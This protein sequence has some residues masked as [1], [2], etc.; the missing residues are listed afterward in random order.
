[1]IT[2]LD[3]LLIAA[4]FLA[5]AFGFSI[6]ARLWRMGR[7]E[8]RK[9]SF[10]SLA[11]TLF[12]HHRILERRG[13]GLAH[14][15]LFWGFLLPLLAV[16]ASQFR[17]KIPAGAAAL[18]S[19]LLDLAGA[20]ALAAMIF[21]LL[22]SLKRES[23]DKPQRTILPAFVLLFILVTGFLAEGARLSILAAPFSWQSP[24]GSLLSTV[25]PS[26]PILM[27]TAIR[28]HFF[29]VLIFIALLPFTFARHLYSA[30]ANVFFKRD[31]NPGE[32]RPASFD[33]EY[34]GAARARDFSWKQLL[35]VD[36]CVSC[37]RCEESCPAAI[38][39]KSLSPLE[40]MRGIREEMEKDQGT[41]FSDSPSKAL[42]EAVR[43]EA[44]WS[45]TTCMACARRCPVYA[46]PVDK[47]IELRRYRTMERGSLPSEAR[48]VLRNI[49]IYGD[50]YGK[51]MAYRNDWA[52]N[53]GVPPMTANAEIL[54]WVGCSG[55]FHPRY[56]ETARAMVKILKAAGVS[57]GVL[58]KQE[59]C[60]G[61]PARRLGDEAL[62]LR[63]AEKNVEIFQKEGVKKIVVLCPHCYNVLKN[64]YSALGSQIEAVHSTEL[65]VDLIRSRKISLDYP[66]PGKLALHDPCY[67]GRGNGVYEPLREIA[68]SVKGIEL[69]ELPRNR[70]AGFC[71]GGG[72]G[73]MW[74]HEASGKRINHIRAEEAAQ[75]G[76]Q[77]VGSACP[78][79]LTMLEDGLKSCDSGR[80]IR[81]LDLVE[82]VASSIG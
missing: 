73:L 69:I 8:D 13:A 40:V 35:D 72:G 54:L 34:P 65:L 76:A 82:I 74:I 28:I 14:A 63:M 77:I 36:A 23:A 53:R 51:G 47:I 12:A 30:S 41:N 79:C 45:C 38:S 11:K 58:G 10:A 25:L 18:L 32:L 64:E 49:E 61:D 27:Q 21:F 67:L 75:S 71:C 20:L 68:G 15:A 2:A 80:S 70:E 29:A 24:V 59:F 56:M 22:R 62:F 44:L 50:V 4:A 9:G 19:F 52:L 6:R 42:I 55:A 1:M 26:S 81:V 78:Y 7:D 16:I 17:P 46:E 37:G 48:T 31:G 5:M 3:P 39:G 66:L 60:C 43:D 33:G 57:F